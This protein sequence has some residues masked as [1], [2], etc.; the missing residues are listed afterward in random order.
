MKNMD[1][2]IELVKEIQKG[3]KESS[4]EDTLEL[5]RESRGGDSAKIDDLENVAGLLNSQIVRLAS[6]VSM[7]CNRQSYYNRPATSEELYNLQNDL[8]WIRNYGNKLTA[9]I[10]ALK[11]NEKEKK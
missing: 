11:E 9:S 6:T 2:T 3:M 4:G 5:I 1:E 7:L 8:I 10:Q